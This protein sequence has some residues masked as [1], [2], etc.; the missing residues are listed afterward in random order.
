MVTEVI[1]TVRASGGDYTTLSAAIAGEA[2]D[3]VAADESC[4]IECY[5]D[6]PNGLDDQVN[7]SGFT[8]DADHCVKITSP[9]SQRHHGIL[10]NDAGEYAGF[11][12]IVVPT[13]SWAIVTANNYVII[14]NIAIDVT[15]T[16]RGGG[17]SIGTSTTGSVVKNCLVNAAKY[18]PSFKAFQL[19]PNSSR[20]AT[21][22]N[23]LAT[24]SEF[25]FGLGY[26]GSVYA[27]NCMSID[28]SVYGF[29]F[30]ENL[31]ASTITLRNCLSRAATGS[32]FSLGSSAGGTRDVQYCASADATADDWG[33]T[34]NRINQTFD[35]VDESADNFQITEDDTGAQRYGI[36]LSSDPIYPFSDDIAAN[37][38]TIP[39]DI[40]AFVAAFSVNV[41]D[42]S[43]YSMLQ[44]RISHLA[45]HLIKHLCNQRYFYYHN[46]T[47]WK[48]PLWVQI[49]PLFPTEANNELGISNQ[50]DRALFIIPRQSNRWGDFPNDDGINIGDILVNVTNATERWYIQDYNWDD[51]GAVC[52]ITAE[53]R[54]IKTTVE[55][56]I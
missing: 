21:I 5:N 50:V 23:C 39:W 43:L 9:I 55:N 54:F 15:N 27:Y 40:G 41:K 1:K 8:T 30:N 56:T 29:R 13:N 47:N 2:R 12:L 35:F 33:G 28:S 24:N 45:G 46:C 42:N 22:V 48:F 49:Q 34:G 38:R 37:I 44:K 11:T 17:I 3:L 10:K 18:Q 16:G 4:T 52:T 6:W 14:E 51:V 53:K 26:R 36:D 25:A 20:T 32:D 7:V 19:S 31:A